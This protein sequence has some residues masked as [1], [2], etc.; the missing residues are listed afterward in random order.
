LTDGITNP[1]SVIQ[2]SIYQLLIH[3]LDKM[4]TL[5]GKEAVVLE[6]SIDALFG[7]DKQH[8]CWNQFRWPQKNDACP[9]HAYDALDALNSQTLPFEFRNHIWEI[10]Q[11]GLVPHKVVLPVGRE[12]VEMCYVDGGGV[13]K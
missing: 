13:S 11:S 6:V 5:K 8:L 1:L 3:G 12:N 7:K 2:Q 10:M 4:E 9:C